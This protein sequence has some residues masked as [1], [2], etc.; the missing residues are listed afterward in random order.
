MDIQQQE[1][2][3]LVAYVHYFRTEAKQYNFMNDT[4]HI[5]NLIKGLKSTHSLPAR[6]YEKDPQTLMGHHHRSRETQ[7]STTAYHN[8][9]SICNGQHDVKWGRL[10]LP[11]P[12]TR[13]WHCPHMRCCE[14]DDTGHTANVPHT[15]A[16]QATTLRTTADQIQAHSMDHWGILHTKEDCTVWD[17]NPIRGPKNHT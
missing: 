9:Y 8:K 14:C 1:K 10:V 16:H 17:H 7:C 6:I 5:R 11:M 3:S 12:R 15:A 2:E 4:A 13:T